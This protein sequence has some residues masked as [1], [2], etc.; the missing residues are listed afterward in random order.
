[1]TYE[2]EM[3]Q[4]LQ[5]RNLPADESTYPPELMSQITIRAFDE[6]FDRIKELEDELEDSDDDKS[7]YECEKECNKCKDE[8]KNSGIRLK[9]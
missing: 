1:M 6:L 2:T 5:N 7:Y 9:T 8:V 3:M 4:Y